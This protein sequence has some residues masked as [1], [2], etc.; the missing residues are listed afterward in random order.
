VVEVAARMGAD[1]VVH[2]VTDDA[3]TGRVVQEAVTATVVST[4]W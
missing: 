4:S 3:A 1:G 2:D